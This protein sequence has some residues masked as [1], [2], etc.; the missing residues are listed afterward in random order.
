MIDRPRR[1]R[2]SA[3]VRRLVR[4]THLTPAQ[5]VLPLFVAEAIDEP[6]PIASMP[7]VVQHTRDTA[8][9]AYAEAAELGLGGVML[10]GVPQRKDAVGSGAL[11]PDGGLGQ[12]CPD[13]V[14]PLGVLERRQ[15]GEVHGAEHQSRRGE[16]AEALSYSEVE[17]AVV[18]RAAL[19]AH[20]ADESDGLHARI[21]ADARECASVV[22]RLG[23]SAGTRSGP[24]SSHPRTPSAIL[25]TRTPCPS[26][27]PSPG[28]R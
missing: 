17:L 3:A 21:L 27:P 1:L 10:F 25:T 26:P 6:R 22:W 16:P 15:L 19:P 28:W 14:P 13:L 18:G 11:D 20:P 24:A 5:L 4:E 23:S 2:S 9:R 12:Q 8:R 7:G